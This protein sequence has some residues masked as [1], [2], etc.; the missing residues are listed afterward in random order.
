VLE[1]GFATEKELRIVGAKV[2]VE[3][4]PEQHHDCMTG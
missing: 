3:I 1:I 2:Y 4:V